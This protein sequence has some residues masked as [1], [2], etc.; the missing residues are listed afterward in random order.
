MT[1]NPL[2]KLD[3][4]RTMLAECR[5][6]PDIKKIREI[7]EAA[8]V[9]A[10][11]AHMGREAANYAAEIKL[12]AEDKAGEF[13]AQLKKDTPQERGKKRDRLNVSRS[14]EYQKV[15]E[16]T[17]TPKSTAIYWQKV[18]KVPDALREKYIAETKTNGEISTRGFLSFAAKPLVDSENHKKRPKSF[19]NFHEQATLG[20]I[21]RRIT[22]MILDEWPPDY[23]LTPLI[24]M[25]RR[26]ADA[27]ELNN[28]KR[29]KNDHCHAE[30][31]HP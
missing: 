29:E 25:L 20:F 4:A 9:Y 14:S 26:E 5:L 16:E 24:R 1:E 17:E 18:A 27:L 19:V 22:N 10:K 12:L 7:A 11:A 6:L 3:K 31:L 15:L 13:L 21:G 8:R 28:R 2:A 23:D 30:S